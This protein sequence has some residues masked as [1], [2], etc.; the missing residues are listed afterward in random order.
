MPQPLRFAHFEVLMRSD[1]SPHMLG[2][3]AMGATYKAL[4]QHLLSL[5]V[6][7]VP[8]VELLGYPAAR[9]RFLQEAQMMA[10]L[11]HPHVANVFY[12][13]ESSSGPFYAMEFC[14]G[15]SLHDYVDQHGPFEVQDTFRLA[16]QAAA[17]L[18]ALESHELIHRDLKPSNILLTS[19][20]TGGAHVKL[21]DFGVAREGTPTDTGG[22]TLGGFIGTPAFASPEQLL[23]ASHLDSRSDLYSLGAV[24][25]FCL[26]GNPPFLGSQF[27][28]MFHHVNTEPDWRLLPEMPEASLTILK[29]LLAKSA[30]ERYAS[31]AALV[32]ALQNLLGIAAA[33]GNTLQLR[34]SSHDN[35]RSGLGG[36][37]PIE[38]IG[39]DDFGKLSLARDILTGNIVN[40][41]ELP[42]EFAQKQGLILRL[43]R[44]AAVL[45]PLD[46]PRWQ[47]LLHFEH[48]GAEC[49]L[50]TERISGPTALH[51]LKAHQQLS[52]AHILPLLTQIAEAMDFAASQGLTAME[53]AIERL[54]I[55]VEGWDK[56]T[57]PERSAL[58]RRPLKDWT[59]W[60]VKVCPLRLS[61]S[62]Q[63]YV[64]PSDSQAAQAITRLSTDFIQLCY[65]LL[66]GQGRSGN[67]YIPSPSLTAESNDFFERHFTGQRPQTPQTCH[68]LLRLLCVAEGIPAPQ[69]PEDELEDPYATR[70]VT[71]R[72]V[73]PAKSKPNPNPPAPSV[74]FT[75]SPDDA[76]TIAP[77]G[78]SGSGGSSGLTGL[79][80]LMDSDTF[81]AAAGAP[82]SDRMRDLDKR[83]A[84]LDAEAER[85]REDER[86]QAERDWIARERAALE[87]ARHD[88]AAHERERA[89]RLADE[90]ARLAEQKQQLE[91][92]QA[93]LEEKRREQQRLEQEIQLRAQLDFQKLQEE[94]KARE[95]DLQ[96]QRA[97]VEEALQARELDFQ[98]REK[99]SLERIEALKNEAAQLEE[100][101]Q[102]EYLT[103]RQLEV[104]QSRRVQEEVFAEE[105]AKEKLAV[106][107]RKLEEMRQQLE[108]RASEFDETKKSRLLILILGS[109]GAIIL[110]TTAAY[111]IKGRIELQAV[112]FRELTGS[113]QW[114]ALQ[115]ER[116][117]AKENQQWAS[118]LAWCTAAEETL[119]TSPESK[120][121]VERYLNEIYLDADRAITG[122]LVSPEQ[123]P[124][125]TSP[126]RN[127]LIDQL[128]KT[129]PWPLDKQRHLLTAKLLIPAATAT[130]QQSQ[131]IDLYLAAIKASPDYAKPLAPELAAILD[132]IRQQMLARQIAS[133]QP[134]LDKLEQ[135]RASSPSETAPPINLLAHQLHADQAFRGSNY[136][137][138]LNLL[139]DAVQTNS[140]WTTELKSQATD[141]I[142]QLS[143]LQP[144]AIFPIFKQIELAAET[145]KLPQAW[146]ILAQHSEPDTAFRY[147]KLAEQTG[148]QKAIAYVGRAQLDTGIAQN[149][150]QLI[151]QGITKLK[152]AVDA[153]D[154][155]A[156][157]L[158]GEAYF[159]GRGVTADPQQSLDLATRA[160][161]KNHPGADYLKGKALLFLGE[162]TG[163]AEHFDQATQLLQKAVEANQPNANFFLYQS[164]FNAVKKNPQRALDALEKG[165]IAKDPLCLYT[166]GIWHYAGQP[167]AKLDQT[168]A[169]QLIE[170]A[171]SLGHPSATKWL[172]QYPK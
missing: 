54:S 153:D 69:L 108:Q 16:V 121:A 8:S 15:P 99:L 86:V 29:R 61:N 65:R 75:S 14:D 170:Q 160:Q 96:R 79:S 4:D 137:Q 53:T 77:R 98:Q 18:Q 52:L 60:S 150:P 27:E 22:L 56:L 123:I 166:L 24:M 131:A 7:K 87:Q 21:I 35:E 71:R 97:A 34:T 76:T 17:A 140:N 33:T 55:A 138:A 89:Q 43:Q 67:A 155:D 30:E 127:K 49:R 168:R 20:S 122:L 62:T 92:Q 70:L 85:L 46:H 128:N 51:L 19:D 40:L 120:D 152:S 47:R 83:R 119:R 130:G 129:K 72:A 141:I 10:R 73:G 81:M 44:L 28:I 101:V 105:L 149:N 117:S 142:D 161:A 23:E 50:A 102:Q 159:A 3:G 12:Y 32:Q 172:Q 156:M 112:D 163:E 36:Y 63:D 162:T 164:Y 146:L 169:R 143:Q 103:V 78:P 66:T 90:Q 106:E 37:E 13:G 31:P 126:D 58:L 148:S 59:N 80:A 135:L 93:L 113:K 115:Q 39:S 116:N 2:Q 136:I 91:Q 25:W 111:F 157:V 100:E 144:A 94:A 42:P 11:R 88:V 151:E 9:Q 68:T 64:L 145:W 124:P 118:L 110:A 41:R 84:E 125:S 57:E 109:L 74:A 104:Q 165:V 6:V 38:V 48:T 114:Q 134:I 133:H 171:A 139:L 132:T 147:F 1:G 158:L 82:V 26:T 5:A 45:R 167:P 154:P 95:S 107:E